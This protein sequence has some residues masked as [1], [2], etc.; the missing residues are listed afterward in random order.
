MR[1]VFIALAVAALAA[2]FAATALAEPLL[3]EFY[4]VDACGGCGK[5]GIG[6]KSCTIIDEI[7]NRYRLMFP[8]LE[9][10]LQFHNLRMDNSQDAV[11]RQRLS[12]FGIDW[13]T[14]SLPVLFVGDGLFAADG[15]MDDAIADYVGGGAYPGAEE[16]VRRRAE[17]RASRVPGRV[18]YLYS[19]Y[20][21]DCRDISR[22]LQYSIPAD[23]EIVRY[24][25]YTEEGQEMERRVIEAL[26]LD[27]DEYMIP[28]IVYGDEAFAG[29]RAIYLS[30]KSR[31]KEFPDLQTTVIEQTEE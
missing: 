8:D 14:I 22:W 24:D 28:C 15:S 2:I 5:V 12:E 16:L 18:V 1:R 4:V 29:K 7:A 3:F 6:C 26:R 20:C 11:M 13:Q 23:Y 19:P 9:I 17:Y 10:E 21:E 25:V 27:A 30:L 31:I